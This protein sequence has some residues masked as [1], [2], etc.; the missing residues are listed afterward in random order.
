[1]IQT[2][3]TGFGKEIEIWKIFEAWFEFLLSGSIWQQ[4]PY[5][6]L[7]TRPS[8]D[9]NQTQAQPTDYS[10]YPPA[11]HR[12]CRLLVTQTPKKPRVASTVCRLTLQPALPTVT[13]LQELHRSCRH[14]VSPFHSASG[15]R[16]PSHHSSSTRHCCSSFTRRRRRENSDLL[17]PIFIKLFATRC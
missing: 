14:P 16:N 8:S 5:G 4:N 13:P 15:R 7:S 17:S 1:M 3:V 10:F 2:C 6:F 12:S 11:P 9:S